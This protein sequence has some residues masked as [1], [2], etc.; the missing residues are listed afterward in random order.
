MID[1][2]A[3]TQ[4]ASTGNGVRDVV[5]FV[6]RYKIIIL[7]PMVLIAS[8][9]WL[10][11][12]A[13]QPRFV[14]KAVLAL[15]ARKVQVV[16]HEI[17]SRLPQEN[18]ALRTEL[19]VIG[20]RSAAEE[21]VD[22][23]KLTSDTEVLQ[24]AGNA[25]SLW[26]SLACDA[27]RALPS[28][29]PWN[30]EICPE[31]AT[32]IIPTLSRS[33]L[34]DWIVGNVKV[35]NDGRS[36]TI[37]VTFTSDNPAVTAR[38][39]NGI[40]ETYLDE[41]V[42]TKTISTVKA[43]DW[44]HDQLITM[45]HEL[46]TSE[47]AVDDFR[48]QSGLNEARGMTLPS[49][50]LGE[51][52]SQLTTARSERAHAEA[53][54]QAARENDPATTPAVLE[55]PII[56]DLRKEKTQIEAQ[57]A[58]N[59][60]RGPVFR[61]DVLEGRAAV[62]RKQIAQEMTRIL[63]GLSSEVQAAHKKEAVLTQTL[64]GIESQATNAAHSSFRLN[65]LQREADANRSM[66]DSL[67]SRYREAMEQEGLAAPDARLISRAEIPGA[68]VFPDKMRFLLFGTIGGLAFGGGLALLRNGFDRRIRQASEVE[69]VTGIPVFGLLPKVSRWRGVQPQDYPV[70]DPHSRFCAALARVHIV[71]RAPKSSDR[72]Q[73]I[74]VTSAQPGD[75]KTSFCTSL[76]RSL[77]NSRIR[78][79]VV[80]ADPYRSQVPSSF[81]ASI[82]QAFAPIVDHPLRLGDI[83]Q[84]DSKSAAHFI[85]A[86]KEEDL[87]L[88]IHSGGFSRLLE[89]ARQAYDIVIID[90]PPVMTSADAALIGRFA[91]TRLLLVSL[92]RTSWDEM[93][94]A[95][96]FLRLCRVG[97]DG[98][99]VVGV[100]TGS[101]SY[102]Q[103]ASYNA[104]P[105]E[106]RV[107]RPRS[108]QN[109]FD[110]Q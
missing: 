10:V 101:L 4:G 68:P 6:N 36:L 11:A 61:S 3:F 50:S 92:G 23:L 46:E 45:R 89:E 48:R 53:K 78:V 51:L 104:T 9:A 15:D 88:L 99:V 106:T 109:F 97:L 57:I 31:L 105:L 7:S 67:L 81:G 83:V 41:Q 59:A 19:D 75:G 87:Q 12:S 27:Q 44:L 5:R 95:V 52:N 107:I 84:A 60:A 58:E 26:Q 66:Y 14:A 20:S 1:S 74:L 64:E 102:G 42:R 29:F 37:D 17:V 82:F 63:A 43:R 28:W 8:A 69:M 71:L 72:A 80:D 35:S 100:D 62:V 49:Q 30:P 18:A 25:S 73:V 77:A 13:T 85:P 24:V 70:K 21:V 110:V 98:V 47:R 22:R 34:A 38:I 90:T 79:L 65:Q 93:T 16:E 32:T 39:A 108:Y 2:M 56:R 91:D 103:L 33:Q 94:A 55:S 54:L 96:G 86:P 40:A 76:A